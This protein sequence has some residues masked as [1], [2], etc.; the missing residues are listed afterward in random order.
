M[1]FINF[2]VINARGD[3]MNFCLGEREADVIIEKVYNM[4]TNTV[5]VNDITK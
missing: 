2:N 3:N 1:E 5:L 4:G